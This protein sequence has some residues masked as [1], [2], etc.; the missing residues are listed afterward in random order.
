MFQVSVL[1]CE[2]RYSNFYWGVGLGLHNWWAVEVIVWMGGPPNILTGGQ[3]IDNERINGS[4]KDS[5]M[6][7]YYPRS[8]I[9]RAISQP[10]KRSPSYHV[11]IHETYR[12]A[13]VPIHKTTEQAAVPFQQNQP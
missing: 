9:H 8:R 13:T 10:S 6:H 2:L 5:M 1:N 7:G 12:Q 11:R 4:K 3:A